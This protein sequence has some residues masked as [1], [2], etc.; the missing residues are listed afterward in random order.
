MLQHYYILP[1]GSSQ[2][3]DIRGDQLNNLEK[4]VERM[5]SPEA[6]T[7]EMKVEVV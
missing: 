6:K 3:S 4:S 1:N 7:A 5:E 2:Q